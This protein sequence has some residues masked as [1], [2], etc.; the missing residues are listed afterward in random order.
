[1]MPGNQAS[2]Y[3][4]DIAFNELAE[5]YDRG[6]TCLPVNMGLRKSIWQSITARVP[7]GTRVLELGCGT[8]ED[9]LF[10][11]RQGIR[12]LATDISEGMIDQARRKLAGLESIAECA[13]CDIS[14]LS[15][16][17]GSGR[18]RFDAIL[19]NFGVLNCIPSLGPV[20]DLAQKH[21]AEDG[22]LFLCLINRFCLRELLRARFRRLRRSGGL[23]KCGA[24]RIAIYYYAPR[25]L[26]WPGFRIVE[27][28][29][30]GVFSSRDVR[31]HA[32]FNRAGD[33]YLAVLQKS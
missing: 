29:G 13:V 23:T 5:T 15:D 21:L 4:A 19:A 20:R 2:E 1:M 28:L 32:P 3:R 18:E 7:P 30:L 27:T 14:R 16:Y 26:R 6:F 11:A 25:R 22:Y 31:R 12:V 24:R 33:H 17:L 8:G 9:A 10:L